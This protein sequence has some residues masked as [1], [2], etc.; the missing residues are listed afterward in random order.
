MYAEQIALS[1]DK[2]K[3]SVFISYAREDSAIAY[4]L[5]ASLLALGF[6]VLIDKTDIA[7]GEDWQNRIEGMIVAADVVVFVLSPHAV[8]SKVCNTAERIR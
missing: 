1:G 6:A 2:P 8:C 4:K 5:E 7:L 3:T